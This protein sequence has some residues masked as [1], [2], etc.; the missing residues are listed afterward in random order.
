MDSYPS[1]ID[2]DTGPDHGSTYS[3]PRWVK[4]FGIIALVLVL[5][6]VVVL[7]TGLGG[8]HGPSRH[9]P[10][11]SVTEANDAGGQTPP[12]EQEVQQP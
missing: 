3:T 11:V 7:V 12:I 2:T 4:R 5:L 9:I 10:P 8:G 1:D 6:V